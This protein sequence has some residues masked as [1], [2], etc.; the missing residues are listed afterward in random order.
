MSQ[1]YQSGREYRSVSTP[2]DTEQSNYGFKAADYIME[3]EM[4]YTVNV[5]V[6]IDGVYGSRIYQKVFYTRSYCY[7]NLD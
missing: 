7:F 1:S 2:R 5:E 4:Y 3:N 6:C